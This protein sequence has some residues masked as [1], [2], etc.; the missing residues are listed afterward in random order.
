MAKNFDMKTNKNN[1]VVRTDAIN[2]FLR[3]INKYKVLSSA[4]ERELFKRIKNGDESAREDII[5]HNQR[6][7]FAVAKT[8]ANDERVL[9]LVNE[10]NIGLMQAIDSY[11]YTKENRFLSYAVWYIRRSINAYIV[12]DEMFIQKT[13]NTKTIYQVGK[14]R[15]KFFSMYGRYPIEEELIELLKE[16]GVKISDISD[17]YELKINS[18]STTYDD[19]DGNAFENSPMFTSKTYTTNEYETDI[20]KEYDSAMSG[21][22]MSV[23]DERERTIIE[24]AFGIGYA[25]SYTNNEIGEII[26]MSAERIR[27]L[28]NGALKKMRMVA[29]ERRI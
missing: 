14:L 17:L 2:Q 27:Q 6:F 20:E 13:N 12:N 21:M 16:K 3:Q 23:L 18:I 10:G 4:E 25:K 8:Y 28:K 22:L 15:T 19:E 7:V 11:D 5:K 24:Y 29:V 1:F 9:D 26:G